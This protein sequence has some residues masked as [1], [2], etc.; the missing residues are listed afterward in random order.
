M[1]PG[2]FERF[3]AKYVPV[4]YSGCWLWDGS[5]V[6]GYGQMNVGGRPGRAHR[7]AYEHFVG[8]I[9]RGA[10]VRHRCDVRCCVNPDHLEVGSYADNAADMV[11]RGRSA[12]GETHSQAR[13]SR[14]DVVEIRAIAR[15][16]PGLRQA[17]IAV[18]FGVCRKTVGN[19]LARRTWAH[20]EDK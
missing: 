4:P 20:V 15:R 2:E 13:L 14:R 5:T 12:R 8:P 18:R 19:V 6:H 1:T 9:P 10:V 16:N 3:E 7:L 17:D 11:G